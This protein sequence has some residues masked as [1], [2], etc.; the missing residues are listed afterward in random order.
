MNAYQGRDQRAIERSI[1]N[2][3]EYTLGLTRFNFKDFNAYQATA[4]SVRD[5]LIEQLNDSNE[6]F[7]WKNCKRVYYLSLEFLLGRMLQNSLVNIDMEKK[8]KDAL[9]DI[10]FQLEE[11]YEEEVDPALGNGGL[12]RLAAC[13]MDSLATLDIPAMGYGIRYDYGIFK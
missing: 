5:R 2:H 11:I 3:V 9:T 6:Y 13:F 7:N 10:G 8:Y 12:G 4:Y 1:V